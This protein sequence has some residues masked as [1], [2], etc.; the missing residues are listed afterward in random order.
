MKND[1]LNKHGQHTITFFK[2]TLSLRPKMH[3]S[4]LYSVQK[5]ACQMRR[6]FKY[7]VNNT[8]M[9]CMPKECN[10]S[11][12]K[13]LIKLS[14]LKVIQTQHLILAYIWSK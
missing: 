8:K 10:A 6:L 7:A 14:V 2:I 1:F 11:V 9:T 5:I 13:K 3:T 12:F 4:L